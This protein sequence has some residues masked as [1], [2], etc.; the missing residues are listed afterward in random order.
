[1]TVAY[2]ST[3]PNFDAS[4]G[5]WYP[6]DWMLSMLKQSVACSAA[7]VLALGLSIAGE[8]A[9]KPASA[10]DVPPTVAVSS[11]EPTALVVTPEVAP[12]VYVTVAP[13]VSTPIITSAP[14]PTS[15]P[16]IVATSAPQA[17]RVRQ[18]VPTYTA[19]PPIATETPTGG[20]PSAVPP[21]S[22]SGIYAPLP[23]PSELRLNARLRWGTR[24]PA[25]VRRWAFL[26]VPAA[27]KYGLDPNLVAAVMTMES[28]GDPLAWSGADA[29][30][31][32]QILHG[33]WDPK[34]NVFTGARMLAQFLAQFGSVRLAL[35]AY[36][37]GP[38]AVESYNGVPPYRET[39]DYVIVVGYLYD[40]FSHHKLGAKR[41]E[42]FTNTLHDLA[43]FADQR[44]RVARVARIAHLRHDPILDPVLLCNRKPAL[45]AQPE[46]NARESSPAPATTR[47]P[48]WPLSGPPD[49]L[50]R[51][52]PRAAP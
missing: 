35:A 15:P 39:R 3:A 52:D 28:A 2:R 1:M 43:H 18:P 37:A 40:L 45:C 36:N 27:Q 51:V 26:I 13:E 8:G 38:G 30:G 4:A 34:T 6:D 5:D 44:K 32:M 11:P 47:D 24:A 29:R 25:A 12:T 16:L 22:T 49:P 10:D 20:Q 41:R 14:P 31:L 42:V 46:S 21:S 9:G 48:F 19:V 33:P 7:L 50:Q 23:S 17:P